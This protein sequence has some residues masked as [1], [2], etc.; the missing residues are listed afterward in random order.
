MGLISVAAVAGWV[1]AFVGINRSNDLKT[2]LAAS[3]T[4]RA[5]LSETLAPAYTVLSQASRGLTL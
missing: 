1:V 2:K 3:E 5:A 4:E